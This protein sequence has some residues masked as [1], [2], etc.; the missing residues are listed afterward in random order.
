MDINS[1]E[2]CHNEIPLD[3]EC[4]PHCGGNGLNCPNVVLARQESERQALDQRFKDALVDATTRGCEALV[5]AFAVAVES[6]KAVMGSTLQ[7]LL[8]I[9]TR[10]RDVFA[11]FHELAEL[12]FLRESSPNGPD[13]NVVRPAAEVA[14]LGG[15]KRIDRLHY[16]ALSL[17]GL[18]LP[19]YGDVSI[20]LR[21]N[22]I[23]HRVSL[24]QE[25][26][27]VYVYRHGVNFPPGTRGMWSERPK[28]CVAKLAAQITAS[29]RPDEFPMILLKPG[30]TG[31]DDN[32]VEIHV[33]GP[34]T[35]RTFEKVTTTLRGARPSSAKRPR[36]RRGTTDE[37]ALQ[38]FCRLHGTECELL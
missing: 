15:P 10:D 14:L 9:L 18:S 5:R 13:W 23:A 8:P 36:K 16:A 25:N 27:A 11:T 12:R 38:D 19:H 29:T 21:E 35:F 32:F 2:R 22:L 26:S 28:L 34:M 7:K 20:V 6:S 30:A 24:F 1:C 3:S 33:F 31:L 17:D 37:L 4:C